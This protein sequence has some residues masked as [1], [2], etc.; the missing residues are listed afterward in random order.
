MPVRTQC[1]TTVILSILLLTSCSMTGLRQPSEQTETAGLPHLRKQGTVTQLVVEGKPYLLLAGELHN[2]STSSIEYM[3]PIWPK[4]KQMNLN[5]VLAVV[6][7]ALIEPEEGKFDF[8]IVDNMIQEARNHDLHLV[9]LWFGSWKN[10]ISHFPP[11]WVKKDLDRFGRVRIKNGKHIEVLS[12]LSEANMDADARAF[13]ALMRHIREVDSSRQTVIMIQV[14][15]EVGVL[16][17]SRDR[18]DA[19]NAAFAGPVPDE[20]MEYLCKYKDSLLPELKEVWSATGYKQS[21]TWTQVFG[22]GIRTDEIFMA[23]HYARY[24]DRVAQTG[25]AQYPI[26]MFVNTWLVQRQDEVP[27]DYPSGG[28]QARNHDIWRAGAPN[29]DILAPDIYLPNFEDI[30]RLYSRSGNPLFIP[31]SRAGAQGAA[32]A[33]L[34]VGKCNAI[35][36]SP[37]GIDGRLAGAAAFQPTIPGRDTPDTFPQAYDVLSQLAPLILEHQGKDSMTALA[38]NNQNPAENI[39]MGDYKL[40]VTLRRQRRSTEVPASGYCIIIM[41]GPDEYVVAGIDCQITFFANTPGP[42]IVGLG[43]VYEGKYVDGRWVPGRKLNG[44]AIMLNYHL[45]QMAAENRPGSVLRLQGEGP[46]IRQVKLYRF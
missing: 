38:L 15:N 33:F 23:W 19:A 9:I 5:T 24:I 2:S 27:G 35:G 42:E 36:Y 34:A 22:E 10:G 25:K 46:V 32:N 3:K 4:L 40:E 7:W 37:F 20:L 13:A 44:D 28:P 12:T 29:I 30:C 21:G 26:P 16:G 8:T 1:I 39:T 41:T 43:S 17:D 18:S 6:S 45:D 11:Y 31:E 14:Q